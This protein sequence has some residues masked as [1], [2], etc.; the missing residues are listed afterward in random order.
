MSR[1]PGSNVNGKS[2]SLQMIETVWNKG[3]IVPGINP[4]EKR[5]DSCGAY[6]ERNQYNVNQD[7]GTGWE[8]DHVKPVSLG[9]ND[10][11]SNLQP[12]QW[13]NNR[14]KADNYPGDVCSEEA[15]AG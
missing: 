1:K 8:I 3:V 2:F 12:L 6:I 14:S 5:K 4:S 10:D 11:I 15:E 9:G 13:Q 7:N